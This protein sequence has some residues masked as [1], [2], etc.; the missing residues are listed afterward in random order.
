[1]EATI[2]APSRC[3]CRPVTGRGWFYYVAIVS[4]LLVLIFSANTAFADF[5]RVCRIIAEDRFLPV[6]LA[7]RGRRLVFTEGI[8]VLAL[9]AA[10]LLILFRGVTDRL[11]PLYAVGAFLAFT[12]S[13]AG[14]VAHWRRTGGKHA[15]G[16]MFL[17]GLGALATGCTV[18]VVAVAKFAEGAWITVLMIP[19]LL[20]LMYWVRRHYDKVGSEIGGAPAL[21]IEKA[22]RLIAVLPMLQW[23]RVGERALR[24]ALA[25]TK[26]LRVLHVSGES[27]ADETRRKLV[28]CIEKPMLAANYPKPDIVVIE[29][30]YRFVVAP[31]VDYVVKVADENPQCR[32]IA[33]LPELVER[34][35]YGYFLHS[36]RSSLLKAQFI[37]RGNDRIS[38][39]N[40]PWYLK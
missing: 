36:Q 14:M 38:V 29:S 34:H 25:M 17:N 40:V 39:L 21:E 37:I 1:M 2:K 13:Q 3:S 24:L 23:S 10:A 35:W 33:V 8:I 12:L 20:F 15:R 28:D 26:E 6:S 4:I 19:A 5:P 9:L 16:S 7:N 32:V 18:L 31:I 27:N 22:E 30:P 11:I